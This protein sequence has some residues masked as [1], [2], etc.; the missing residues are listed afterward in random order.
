VRG[1]LALVF[2]VVS[3]AIAA[4]QPLQI[5][6]TIAIS[7]YQDS[8]LDRQLV[9]GPG[10]MIS[11]PLAGQI[12]ATGLTPQALEKVLRTKLRSKYTVDLDVA[13]TV[14]AAAKPDDDLK[15]RFYVTGEVNRPGPYVF[16]TATNVVQAI[17]MSGGLSQFAARKRVQVR[18]KVNGVESTFLFDY[19]AFESGKDVSGN[20]DLEPGDVVLVPERGLWE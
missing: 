12:K 16:R 8:K 20:I 4:A 11:F 6:D 18:R 7:V 1:L 14:V 19:A 17:A 5:G 13:V 2:L 3:C 9:I 10:G 15:P